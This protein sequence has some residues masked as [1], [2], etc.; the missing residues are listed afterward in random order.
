MEISN[1]T[2]T[3]A[4]LIRAITAVDADDGVE[5]HG[6]GYGCSPTP[7]AGTTGC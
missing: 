6:F 1:D 2:A 4:A 3:V 7:R 5:I